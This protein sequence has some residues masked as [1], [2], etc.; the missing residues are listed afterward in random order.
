MLRHA[1]RVSFLTLAWLG[2][3]VGLAQA[4]PPLTCHPFDI[5]TAVSL[6]WGTGPGWNTPDPAYDR[7]RLVEDTLRLLAPD[8]SI[9]ARAE[10]LRRASIYARSDSALS[11]ALQARINA[12]ANAVRTSGAKDRAAALAFFDAGTFAAILREGEGRFFARQPAPGSNDDSDAL[13]SR[14]IELVGGN[15]DMEFVA[16]L[17]TA[18]DK[19]PSHRQHVQKA[20]AGAAPGSL[21]DTNLRQN[22]V[23]AQATSAARAQQ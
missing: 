16:A 11:K 9:L 8:L 18:A 22:F 4:G 23:T 10:T 1:S 6:P 13:I 2:L 7:S 19:G 3:S 17:A 14:A 5:G 21:L 15:A 20:I 12:R